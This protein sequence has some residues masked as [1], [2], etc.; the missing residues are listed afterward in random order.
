MKVGYPNLPPG[1]NK[2]KIGGGVRDVAGDQAITGVGFA[3]KVL[4]LIATGTGGTNQI[5]SIGFDDGIEHRCHFL[6]GDQ[7]NA[8]Y[9]FIKSICAWKDASNYIRAIVKSMDADGFTLTW[10]LTGAMTCVF[11]YVAMR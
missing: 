9:A 10:D 2:I 6:R 8:D 7:V 3:P 11:T 4:I 1:I 5:L